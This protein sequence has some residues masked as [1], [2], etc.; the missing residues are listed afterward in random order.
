MIEKI[1]H[2]GI[3]VKNL[4]QAIKF[5]EDVLGITCSG[6]EEVAEQ[7]VK[8]AFL[9]MGETK[10]ELL[11]SMSPDG[12]VA[13]FIDS[14][15]EGIHHIALRVQN[16]EEKIKIMQD[17]GVRLIDSKPRY[18]AGEARIA[19]VHPKSTSGILLELCERK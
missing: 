7:Q 18:G 11:E 12:P 5:Y 1:D 13:K 16:I 9:P 3:A 17:K 10:L 6:T 2:L 19:F 14:K 15:G 4:T 8:V